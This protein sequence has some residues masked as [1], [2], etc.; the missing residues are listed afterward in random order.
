[1]KLLLVNTLFDKPRTGLRVA[2]LFFPLA[3]AACGGGSSSAPV[4]PNQGASMN[5]DAADMAE[6]EPAPEVL[7]GYFIDS[8]VS[9]L[10]YVT[11]TQEGFTSAQGEFSYLGGEGVQ[12][13]IGDI[14]LPPVLGVPEITP[15][16]LVGT[17]NIE[18][19]AV[20]NIARLLQTLDIDGN[21]DNG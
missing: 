21:P 9:G 13:S 20:V 8:A 11:A 2:G 15:L 7:I 4:E 6:M 19:T 1:M 14:A 12:F 3:L 16:T 17:D 10:K 18:D 5:P